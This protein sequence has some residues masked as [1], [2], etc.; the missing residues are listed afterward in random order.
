[1]SP[2]EEKVEENVLLPVVKGDEKLANIV[3]NQPEKSRESF[4]EVT[5]HPQKPDDTL[6]CVSCVVFCCDI[7]NNCWLAFIGCFGCCADGTCADCLAG[8]CLGCGQFFEA[9]GGCCAD[10]MDCSVFS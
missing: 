1:M 4:E 7:V 5:L 3:T 6:D 9:C 2:S 10:C 8:L